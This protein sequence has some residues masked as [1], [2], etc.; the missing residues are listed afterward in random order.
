MI[1]IQNTV[2]ISTKLYATA[3]LGYAIGLVRQKAGDGMFHISDGLSQP[4]P[5]PKAIYAGLS[6][7]LAVC[8]LP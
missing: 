8:A 1:S 6:I 4:L 2:S 3:S 7:L 5:P